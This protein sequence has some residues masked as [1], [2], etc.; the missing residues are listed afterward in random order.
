MKEPM[1]LYFFQVEPPSTSLYETVD[2]N[3]LTNQSDEDTTTDQSDARIKKETDDSDTEG[4]F[5]PSTLQ[6]FLPSKESAYYALPRQQ[7][8]QPD[9]L[10]LL[11]RV[12]GAASAPV[13]ARI[14]PYGSAEL[15]KVS[16]HPVQTSFGVSVDFAGKRD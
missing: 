13:G 9:Q 5:R 11:L 12:H 4:G 14:D 3:A 7:T 10:A 8:L 6:G 1:R 16:S 15:R 2:L